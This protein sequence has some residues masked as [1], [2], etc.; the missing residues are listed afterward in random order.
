VLEAVRAGVE[1][2]RIRVSDRA[3]PSAPLTAL[4]EEA[5]ARHLVVEMA[6][7]E[8]LD[9]QSSTGR[10]QGV[11]AEV[12][13]PK[14]LSLEE[15]FAR[16]DA[17]RAQPF[18]IVLDGLEDPQNVGAIARSAEAAGANGLILPERG[19]AGISP[20]SLRA[21]AGAILLLPTAVVP[22]TARCLEALKARGVW[23]AGADPEGERPYHQA[24]LDGPIALVLGGEARGLHRLVRDRC[25][26][27]VRVPLNGTV[28]SLNASA[29]AAVILFEVARQRAAA[30]AGST[31]RSA[32]PK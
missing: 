13:I 18:Y 10:H 19:S 8:A 17:A 24:S 31:G 15:L 7:P 5:R 29:A 23:I 3:E 14:A 28:E 4:L 30:A 21:S 2:R 11:I 20:G 26:F 25:D 1:V 27:L 6:P 32:T 22:N 16:T 9:A 12:R